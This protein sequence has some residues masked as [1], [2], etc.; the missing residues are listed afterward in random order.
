MQYLR[1]ELH[2]QGYEVRSRKQVITKLDAPY[3][4]LSIRGQASKVSV[5][6]EVKGKE[7]Q[8]PNVRLENLMPQ[9]P[10][11][12]PGTNESASARVQGAS[13]VNDQKHEARPLFGQGYVQKE[14]VSQRTIE[15]ERRRLARKEKRAKRERT[16]KERRAKKLEASKAQSIKAQERNQRI[17]EREEFLIAENP[18]ISVKTAR[19][20]ARM[21][22]VKERKAE[23]QENYQL[24]TLANKQAKE[25]ELGRSSERKALM[26]H[27]KNRDQVK[28]DDRSTFA[29]RFTSREDGPGHKVVQQPEAQDAPPITIKRHFSISLDKPYDKY[30]AILKR[31]P[32]VKAESTSKSTYFPDNVKYGN[33]TLRKKSEGKSR[34]TASKGEED[35]VLMFRRHFTMNPYERQQKIQQVGEVTSRDQAMSLHG[36]YHLPLFDRSPEDGQKSSVQLSH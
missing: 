34:S 12:A 16:R 13:E 20:L 1:T 4:L 35:N 7:L 24:Q 5:S 28:T 32:D 14:Q 33:K 2:R 22:V 29:V 23:K 26:M 9:E 21:A 30:G 18:G 8:A 31:K 11:T 17:I 27:G 15:K 10:L 6:N 19:K 3:T 36:Q 25:A